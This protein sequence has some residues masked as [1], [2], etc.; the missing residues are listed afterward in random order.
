MISLTRKLVVLAGC[1]AA[2]FAAFGQ[3]DTDI[4]AG[5]LYEDFS[6]TLAPGRGIEAAGPL[7]YSH[8]SENEWQWALPP[9]W[10][11]TRTK[12]LDWTEWEVLYPCLTYRRFGG[13]SMLQI[14]ELITFSGG[15]TIRDRDAKRF[16]I[17]PLYFQQRGPD[18]DLNYTAVVPFGGEMKNRLFR[19]DI[20]FVLFPLYSETR[21]K[22][23]VTD[24]YVFPIFDLR[25]GNRLRG[26]QVWP[27]VG[28]EHKEPTWQT[29]TL[30]EV[31]TNGGYD[32]LFAGWPIFFK[33]HSGLGT[34]NEERS[35][36]VVPFYSHTKSGVREQTSYGWPIGYNIIDDRER[37]YVEH[38]YFWP[39]GV[40]AHGTKQ[41]K[42][43]FPFFSQAKNSV[44]ESDYYM[45]PVYKF[46]RLQTESLE[47]RRTRV[48]Y[49]LYS[50]T[51]ETNKSSAQKSHR[52]DFWPFYS[53]H[54][55]VNGDK[56]WQALA[57]LEPFFPNNR[58]I[59]REYAQ[60]WSLW[61]AEKNHKT[62]VASQSLL[63]NLYRHEEGPEGEKTLA[64]V[65]PF[66]VSI[67]CGRP[68]LAG[69]LR[70]GQKRGGQRG[71]A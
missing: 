20:K 29:N 66:S 49:F 33:S 23:V 60:I 17:F 35:L 26:W 39:V 51:T 43:V 71:R 34:T 1:T 47:R 44:L 64:L 14:L 4:V 55:D 58:T 27:I 38:D 31:V 10:C 48:L 7:Y 15:K 28:V 52:V 30:D 59:P 18:K 16:T 13:E 19:D 21:K 25:H 53:Y 56:R 45:W 69:F 62:G 68:P 2:S 46:N 42:R 9:V 11:Y 50:N 36:T 24:N 5:P 57:V 8:E 6:L 54:R 32:K 12:D 37:G 70:N 65:R 41:E 3:D 40:F 67:Q 61:R 63:W 22:D